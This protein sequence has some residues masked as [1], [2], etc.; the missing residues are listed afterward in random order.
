M[1]SIRNKKAFS[2]ILAIVISVIVVAAVVVGAAWYLLNLPSNQKM[3]TYTFTDLTAI[4]V[5]SAFKV[6]VTFPM[7]STHTVV[8]N[9]RLIS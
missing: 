9:I 1:Q 6:N 8:N 7:L 2:T 4:N 3:Q 5:S